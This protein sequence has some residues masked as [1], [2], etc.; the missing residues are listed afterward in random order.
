M[1]VVQNQLLKSARSN[2]CP[3]IA[4]HRDKCLCAH[5]Q[6]AGKT[7][8]LVALAIA[9]GRQRVYT[10]IPDGIRSTALPSSRLL[11]SVSV[12]SGR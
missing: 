10:G 2:A 11:I 9:N 12:A 5:G 4:Y 8:M 6:G 7:K 3:K 1:R